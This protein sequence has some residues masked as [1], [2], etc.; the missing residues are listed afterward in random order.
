MKG[1]KN[2]ISIMIYEDKKKELVKQREAGDRCRIYTLRISLLILSI[3]ILIIGWVCIILTSFFENDITDYAKN[4]PYLQHISR[5]IG[6]IA[7]TV[8]NYIVPK[9]LGWITE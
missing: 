1:I 8:V 2:I 3:F 7:L 6:A 9:I 5:Y 4:V